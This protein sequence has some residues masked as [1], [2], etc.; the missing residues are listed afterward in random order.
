MPLRDAIHHR[1]PEA[2][3]A[4]ALGREEGF[5][6]T[7]LRVLVHADA[8][9]AHLDDHAVPFCGGRAVATFGRRDRARA[10]CQ[11][12]ALRHRIDG[13][14]DQVGQRLAHFALDAEDRGQARRELGLE[15]DD[16]AAL[17]RHVAPAR[18]REVQHLLSQRVQLHR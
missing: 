18:A 1:Q 13:I 3:A 14:E 8:G 11:H 15:A 12:A 7:P 9:V 17:L 5:Q 6:A 10:H 16:D 4:F 2:S